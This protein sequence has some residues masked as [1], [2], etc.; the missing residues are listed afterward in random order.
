LYAAKFEI[1]SLKSILLITPPRYLT[2]F[3]A[4]LELL[5]LGE[6][7]SPSWW[8]IHNKLKHDR[9]ANLRKAQLQVAIE[10]LCGL[11]LIIAT[12]P[13][14]ARAVLRRGWIPG[15][16]WSP[17]LTIEMLEGK[18]TG[19]LSILVESKLFIIARGSEKF[20]DKLEDFQPPLFNASDRVL[21]F[22]GSSY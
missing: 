2:P 7:R 3:S 8:Q 13:E 16:K 5:S 10:S 15:T 20:P 12:V 4:W 9:I 18:P 19:S 21:D 17:D 6:Y 11:H 1:P 22:F 14:F